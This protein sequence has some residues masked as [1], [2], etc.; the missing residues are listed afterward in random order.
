MQA[1]NSILLSTFG[2]Q[3]VYAIRAASLT[4]RFIS[5]N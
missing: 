5:V 3:L 2:N 4:T 1:C